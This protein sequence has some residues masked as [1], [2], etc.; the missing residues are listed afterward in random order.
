MEENKNI[1]PVALT[2]G[3]RLKEELKERG[4]TQKDFARLIGV[5]QSH[6]SE[7]ING[8][9]TFTAQ[10]AYKLEDT[11]KI[12]AVTWLDLQR[13]SDGRGDEE[14][15]AL[16]EERKAAEE[17]K[18]FGSIMNLNVLL[19]DYK[20]N[21]NVES[22]AELKQTY[23]LTNTKDLVMWFEGKQKL[24]R[25]SLHFNQRGGQVLTW[26]L[27]TN[28]YL[29]QTNVQG[30]F[31]KDSFDSVVTELVKIFHSNYDTYNMVCQ[32]LSNAGIRFI[33]NTIDQG[34]FVDSFSSISDGIPS[35]V[36]TLRRMRIDDFAFN[37]LHELWFVYNVLGERQTMHV[38]FLIDERE[39]TI[40][41][42]KADEF[43]CKALVPDDKW[44]LA[45]SVFINAT[46]IQEKYSRWAEENGFNKW[47]VMGRIARETGMN[48]FKSDQ[49]RRI[50]NPK[51]KMSPDKYVY[52]N[53]M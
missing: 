11:L 21:S 37:V 7:Y 29:E 1:H 6:L 22:L 15:K 19:M 12:S 40:N 25:K 30:V 4:L 3:Q 28:K 38:H 53:D 41:E 16:E 17:L 26:V 24:L 5:R 52:S 33:R 51:E 32:C 34:L 20:G 18:D 23:H 50:H 9:R 10:F 43:A 8:I 42:R 36:L 46:A 35:I 44:K 27:I 13:R 39:N 14:F 31:S 49:T 45:P 2:P 47:I 48:M